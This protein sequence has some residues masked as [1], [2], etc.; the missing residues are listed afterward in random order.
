[1]M[2]FIK[3]H[4]KKTIV[5][6]IT[7]VR[8]RNSHLFKHSCM[9]NQPNTCKTDFNNISSGFKNNNYRR[10]IADVLLIKQLKPLLNVQ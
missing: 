2:L 3:K 1:M 6:I 5:N 9:K 7:L 10:K 8:D 4:V